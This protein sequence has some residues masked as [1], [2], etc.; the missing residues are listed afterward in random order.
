M[1]AFW[2]LAVICLLALSLVTRPFLD[3]VKHRSLGQRVLGKAFGGFIGG[4][5]FLGIIH[6][7]DEDLIKHANAPGPLIIA[8]NHP[9]LWDAPLVLRRFVTVT[10][11]MKSDL[12]LKTPSVCA[13]AQ[14]SPLRK[15]PSTRCENSLTFSSGRIL[16]L[17]PTLMEMEIGRR[18]IFQIGQPFWR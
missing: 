13:V 10:C 1:V 14:P 18:G 16:T 5:E 4:L 12:R 6:V 7:S 3:S 9:A 17:S 15:T 2:P 8:C 11:I